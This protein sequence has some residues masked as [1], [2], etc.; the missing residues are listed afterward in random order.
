[1]QAPPTSDLGTAC[2]V[3]APT[4]QLCEDKHIGGCV[5]DPSAELGAG[6]VANPDNRGQPLEKKALQGTLVALL[7][8][9]N[10]DDPALQYT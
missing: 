8:T 1:M 3:L 10:P 9:Q 4:P 5:R 2:T 6:E 7:I